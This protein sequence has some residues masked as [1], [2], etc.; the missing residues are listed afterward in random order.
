MTTDEKILFPFIYMEQSIRQTS[1]GLLQSN[2]LY[3]CIFHEADRLAL[4]YKHPMAV[5]TKWQQVCHYHS[6]N[7]GCVALSKSKK[8]LNKNVLHVPASFSDKQT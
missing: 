2:I 6:A 1:A 7:I 8:H 3:E 4:G 5:A